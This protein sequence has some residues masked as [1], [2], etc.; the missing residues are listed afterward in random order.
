MSPFEITM[1]ACFGFA[2]PFSIAKSWKTQNNCG[3]SLVFLCIVLTGYV[4]GI[5]H[6]LFYSLDAVIL[7]YLLNSMMVITDIAIF[8]RN[9][10]IA[11]KKNGI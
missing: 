11:A 6:K 5:L 1:L 4:A 10:A 3:K 7:F 8:L 9:E 2:W